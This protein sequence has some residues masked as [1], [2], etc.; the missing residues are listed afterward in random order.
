MDSVKWLVRLRLLD[1]A[2]EGHFQTK[3]YRLFPPAGAAAPP[4]PIG[5]VRVNSL[6]TWPQDGAELPSGEAVR[7]VGCAWSG[8]GAI[9]QVE[10]SVD[11][12]STW[13]DAQLTGP[14]APYAWRLW[15]F[16]WEPR[17]PGRHAMAVRAVDATGATQPDQVEWNAK[18]YANNAIPRIEVHVR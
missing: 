9:R 4:K 16:A 14:E 15:E 18:G 7:V 6:I 10:I 8:S 11:G 3:D 2:F 17:S 13:K 12:G 5:A 1:H